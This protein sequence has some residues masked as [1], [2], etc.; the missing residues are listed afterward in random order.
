MR[1]CALTLLVSMFAWAQADRNTAPVLARGQKLVESGELAAAQKLYET[2]L[3]TTPDDAN[4]RF[5]LGMIFFRQ[6]DWQ[7]AADNFEV[8]SRSAPARTKTLFYLAEA[9]FLMSDVDR[10]RD[11]IAKAAAMA[12]DDAQ[13]S[14][15]YGEYLSAK[16]DTRR[17]GL[18]QLQ[19][20]R[21]LNAG[22][23]RIDFD[24]GKTQFELTDYTGAV[25]SLETALRKNPSDGEAA[26]FLAEA[27]SKLEDW[28]KAQQFY[29][30]SL[31]HGYSSG[32]AYYGLGRALAEL[33]NFT[34]AVDPLRH[35]L[36]LQ[37][38]LIQ[39]HFQLSRT[40]RQ[41]GKKDEAQR[42]ELLF[43]AMSDR[44]DTS[45]ELR[46]AEEDAAWRHVKPLLES[47]QEQKALD[48]LATL[49]IAARPGGAHYLLGAMYFSAGET[50]NAARLLTKAES[51]AP[52]DARVPAHLGMV[53]MS[54]SDLKGAEA[55][56]Q[57]A[58]QL[59]SDQALA[60]IGMGGIRYQQQRWGDA[61]AYLEKSRTADP[62]TLL[63]LCDAY[64]QT[65]NRDSALLTAEVV[66]AFGSDHPEVLQALNKLLRSFE[67]QSPSKE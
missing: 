21:R 7:K 18:L 14:Q 4:L 50:H 40:Y 49:P 1:L 22:V 44:V 16:I 6:R 10:A 5:E 57:S 12:P 67:A 56:F 47:H 24:V 28:Q 30:Y 2:A 25:L 9:Y 60:L 23:E 36:V 20:A 31:A 19:K 58:L 17:D 8:S 51:L 35:A 48:Y 11:T 39:A 15:K 61:I 59:E 42:E 26:F 45:A 63:L 29:E 34:A 41:L 55:S 52:T 38:S 54:S 32:A 65:G 3:L 64:F 27:S 13:I 33:G 66:R 53:Q 43:A 37:P 46:G 62:D